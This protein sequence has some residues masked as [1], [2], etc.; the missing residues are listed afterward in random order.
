ML[1]AF[2]I[3]LSSP[4]IFLY[5][6]LSLS[7]CKNQERTPNLISGIVF[8]K[9]SFNTRN[10]GNNDSTLGNWE[11][12]TQLHCPR[13]IYSD[14]S[15]YTIDQKFTKDGNET[16]D[17]PIGVRYNCELRIKSFNINNIDYNPQNK[18][19]PFKIKNKYSKKIFGNY[20]NQNDP[21]DH[22]FITGKMNADNFSLH[23][24]EK[25]KDTAIFTSIYTSVFNDIEISFTSLDDP[26]FA[27][28][29]IRDNSR[30]EG[31]VI[32]NEINLTDLKKL[33]LQQRTK[34][35]NDIHYEGNFQCVDNDAED[36]YIISRIKTLNSGSRCALVF[37]ADNSTSTSRI[38]IRIDKISFNLNINFK[39]N[40]WTAEINQ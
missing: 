30:T 15:S 25:A 14:G 6:S 40:I 17:F 18:N 27:R 2:G 3:I 20:V 23:L 4:I 10:S 26:Q 11:V 36:N 35:S 9:F 33:S 29:Q 22:K 32:I 24:F 12:N 1:K 38:S 21:N 7:G 13:L 31:S 16:I 39:E 19:S 8:T 5:L 37:K 28:L 34:D